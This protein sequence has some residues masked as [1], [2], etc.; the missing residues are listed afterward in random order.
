MVTLLLLVACKPET[1]EATGPAEMDPVR[2][3]SRISLDLRGTRPTDDEIASV[4]ADPGAL[5]GL[6]DDLLA[7]ERFEARVRD[8]YSEIYLTRTEDLPVS[9]SGFGLDD[10]AAFDRAVGDEPLRIVGRVAAEDLPYTEVVLGDWTMADETLASFLPLDYPSDGEGWQV[11][12]YTDGRPPAGVLATTGL[13]WRYTSTDSNANR[14]RANA[15]S[16]ILLCNDYLDRPITFSRDLDLLDSDAVQN[17][18]RTNEACANCHNSLDPIASYMFGFWWYETNSPIEISRYHPEREPLWQDYTEVSP[19]WY[20]DPGSSLSDLAWQVASDPRFPECAAKQVSELLLRRSM[21]VADGDRLEQHRA[22]FLAG[23]LTLRALFKSVVQDED[24][25]LAPGAA[26]D[27]EDVEGASPAKML[28]PD[29]LGSAVE[30]LTGFSWTWYGYDMLGT[31]TVG[32]RTLAGGVDGSAVTAVAGSPNATVVLVQERLAEAAASY[33]VASEA[34]MDDGD[35]RLFTEID[36]TETPD[37]G[38]DAVVAQIQ[39]LQLRVLGRRVDADSQE[40][41]AN[42]DLWGELYAATGSVT[43]SWTGLL[44]ALLRDPDFLIY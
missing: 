41:E 30:D 22:D 16:R 29:Q 26:E 17:A 32:V 31:D 23:G 12:H 39:A 10:E 38:R 44:T 20:G 4:E 15:I 6:T 18:I 28:T 7:D 14:R 8:L 21:S 13:W 24:Y 37:V 25:R 3:L 40:V 35:R 11:A 42:L 34:A 19:A 33:A 1:T 43:T 36:F 5:D 2:L 27:G 9:A